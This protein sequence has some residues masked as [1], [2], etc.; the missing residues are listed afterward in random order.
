MFN[1]LFVIMPVHEIYIIHPFGSLLFKI[2]QIEDSFCLV[3]LAYVVYTSHTYA[4]R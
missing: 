3:I 4:I 1:I 2:W